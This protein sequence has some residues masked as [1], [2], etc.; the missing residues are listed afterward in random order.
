MSSLHSFP[1]YKARRFSCMQL[2]ACKQHLWIPIPREVTWWKQVSPWEFHFIHDTA[3]PLQSFMIRRILPCIIVSGTGKTDG[4]FIRIRWSAVSKSWKSRIPTI[5]ATCSWISLLREISASIFSAF[6][7]VG[8]RRIRKPCGRY[9]SLSPTITTCSIFMLWISTGKPKAYSRC[10]PGVKR[11][12][13]CMNCCSWMSRKQHWN[14]W[15]PF[16]LTMT[17]YCFWKIAGRTV[18]IDFQRKFWTS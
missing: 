13:A 5:S 3:P 9:W 14:F 10:F 8:R 11:I 7:I 1:V 12:R 6:S 4:R 15:K 18:L 16:I 17:V 2:N